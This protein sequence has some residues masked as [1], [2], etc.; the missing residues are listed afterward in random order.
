[1]DKLLLISAV[2]RAILQEVGSFD[3]ADT[4]ERVAWLNLAIAEDKRVELDYDAPFLFLLRRLFDGGHSIWNYVT[5]ERTVMCSICGREIP[6]HDA[7]FVNL[8]DGWAH[9]NTCGG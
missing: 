4:G 5:V 3:Y 2:N 7:K 9:P 6:V 1:M 8:F